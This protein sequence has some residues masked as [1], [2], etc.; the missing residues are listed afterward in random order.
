MQRTKYIYINNVLSPRNIAESF[1]RGLLL[2][3]LHTT[4]L[5]VLLLMQSTS[6]FGLTESS[7]RGNSQ[8]RTMQS[9]NNSW[10]CRFTQLDVTQAI[11]C[12]ELL[13]RCTLFIVMIVVRIIVFGSY[14]TFHDL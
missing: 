13:S 6:K 4:L 2:F 9:F 1:H 10:N 3:P 5:L 11:A 7:M 14:K 12:D 8:L